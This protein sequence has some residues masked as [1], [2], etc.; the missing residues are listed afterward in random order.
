MSFTAAQLAAI[1]AAV[2]ADATAL[3]DWNAGNRGT[4]CDY[5]NSAPATGATP[6]IRPDVTNGELFHAL[7]ATEVLALSAAQL[8]MLQLAGQAGT[9]DFTNPNVAGGLSAIFASSTQTYKNV[10]AIAQRAATR[11]EALF[12]TN[13]V[14]A[15]YGAQ[16]DADT[17]VQA[18]K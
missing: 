16:I 14:C 8:V 17:L 2:N 6:I 1:K 13:G 4:C 10:M 7:V 11:L 12:V 3:A 15:V 5:L 9:I 18:M